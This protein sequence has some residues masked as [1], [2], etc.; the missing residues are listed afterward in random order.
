MSAASLLAL[1]VSPLQTSAPM[2]EAAAAM[3]AH[4]LEA[5]PVVLDALS[6][7]PL[8]I[9]R[10]ADLDAC[11]AAAHDQQACFVQNHLSRAFIVARPDDT[12]DFVESARSGTAGVALVVGEDGR[13][14]GTIV[15][16]A[17]RN[18]AVTPGYKV[19]PMAGGMQGMELIWRCGD[20][21][22]VVHRPATPPDRCPDCDAPREHFYL[23]T[24][25]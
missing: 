21:G 2:A 14:T 12:V 16:P 23:V 18:V 1:D 13:L 24:E 20:C 15:A 22:Y 3:S 19:E 7:K 17:G 25:D 4:A 8:G 5:V 10:Q 6:K 11:R 9:V